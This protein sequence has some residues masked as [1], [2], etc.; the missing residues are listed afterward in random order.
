MRADSFMNRHW[1]QYTGTDAL[2]TNAAEIAAQF[3]HPDDA[4]TTMEAWDKAAR[5]NLNNGHDPGFR[6]LRVRSSTRSFAT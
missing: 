1:L 5:A 4:Q 2:P 6:S 3:V